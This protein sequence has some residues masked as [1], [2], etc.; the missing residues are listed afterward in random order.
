M[1]S[2][3]LESKS[4]SRTLWSLLIAI[5]FVAFVVLA[6]PIYVIRPFRPQG[7]EELAVSLVISRWSPLMTAI[8]AGT[9]IV[10]AMVLTQRISSGRIWLKR[11]GAIFIALFVIAIAIASRVNIF[12]KMFHPITAA[13]FL[14]AAQANTDDREMVL[15]VKI[16]AEQRAYPVAIMAYHHLLN[17]SLGGTPLVVT[18]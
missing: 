16:G 4:S 3:P 14:P 9:S 11:S 8:C 2:H 5:A 10:L 1:T 15:A 12:E 13:Q 18:Y 17:D 7:A 6:F